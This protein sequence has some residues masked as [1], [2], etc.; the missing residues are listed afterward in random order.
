MPYNAI[1]IN[2]TKLLVWVI[3]F[4]LI[5]LFT[6]I[7]GIVAYFVFNNKENSKNA[8]IIRALR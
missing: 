6:I 3:V 8:K 2:D 1:E 4:S 7:V 5:L